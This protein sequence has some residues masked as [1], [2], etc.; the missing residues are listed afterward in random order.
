MLDPEEDT[1]AFTKAGHIK[2]GSVLQ[3]EPG[4]FDGDADLLSPTSDNSDAHEQ[5]FNGSFYSSTSTGSPVRSNDT[6]QTAQVL[7]QEA[8]SPPS[9]HS[10]S[11]PY[12][13]LHQSSSRVLDDM[14]DANVSDI[15][16]QEEQM[17]DTWNVGDTTASWD[18]DAPEPDLSIDDDDTIKL[19]AAQWNDQS[20]AFKLDPQLQEEPIEESN[21]SISLP[22]REPAFEQSNE[23]PALKEPPQE[24]LSNPAPS[25]DSP[26][27]P[28]PVEPARSPAPHSPDMSENVPSFVASTSKHD[29]QDELPRED[30][31]MDQ[32]P[33]Q[34]ATLSVASLR[35]RIRELTR[36]LNIVRSHSPAVSTAPSATDEPLVAPLEHYINSP[37]RREGHA[38]VGD[39]DVTTHT[40][41]EVRFASRSRENSPARESFREQGLSSPVKLGSAFRPP[42]TP[43]RGLGNHSESRLS[44]ESLSPSPPSSPP[45][46]SIPRIEFS[47]AAQPVVSTSKAQDAVQYADV[48]HTHTQ[49]PPS[50]E[51]GGET[52]RVASL[53]N[54]LRGLSSSPA[55]HLMSSPPNGAPEAAAS[56]SAVQSPRDEFPDSP[57]RNFTHQSPRSA[58]LSP[59]RPGLFSEAK[60][61]SPYRPNR[62]SPLKLG[63]PLKY[64]ADD[65]LQGPDP[66]SPA[67]RASQ[68]LSARSQASVDAH[69]STP[70]STGLMSFASI[71]AAADGDESEEDFVSP[72]SNASPVKRGDIPKSTKKLMEEL[73]SSPSAGLMSSPYL[74]LQQASSRVF[75]NTSI[76]VEG[77]LQQT[78]QD[79]LSVRSGRQLLESWAAENNEA[80]LENV[81]GVPSPNSHDRSRAEDALKAIPQGRVQIRTEGY[82]NQADDLT[83]ERDE[84]G[85]TISGL[86]D[87]TLMPFPA[88]NTAVAASA[89]LSRRPKTSLHRR[90]L[91][92]STIEIRS[93]DPEIAAR[94]AAILTTQHDYHVNNEDSEWEQ[95][96]KQRRRAQRL[97]ELLSRAQVEI[98]SQVDEQSHR[99]PSPQ[100][101]PVA[102][103][104]TARLEVPTKR[105]IHRHDAWTKSDWRHLE[106]CL[107]QLQKSYYDAG[108][109]EPRPDPEEVLQQFL[110]QLALTERALHGHWSK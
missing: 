43:Y 104:G 38:D 59:A 102:R 66:D 39:L 47:P 52:S 80:A 89:H 67:S 33:S 50:I 95:Q 55:A 79:R 30:P 18:M 78:D 64:Q 28:V 2:L 10:R 105:H 3:H 72:G 53:H 81:Q 86:G 45:L 110:Q 35:Q 63:S 99:D 32:A 4:L 74:D 62:S 37:G 109:L 40:V 108:V 94:V 16:Q 23:E 41:Q 106:A 58:E 107:K 56:I 84:L 100:H 21:S 44:N 83:E 25:L 57:R 20:Q 92:G 11:S 46:E 8:T 65:P 9:A 42:G 91:S 7:I 82:E 12:P 29:E 101:S 87:T 49:S 77:K 54:M 48:S 13:D 26:A 93:A 36:P 71:S 75:G 68:R 17:N 6:P 27:P 5:F 70:R 34:S 51:H 14:L 103:V 69:R 22:A 15:Q 76:G 31:I 97:E 60:F 73:T 19:P 96:E 88:G 90:T 1:F 24:I 61:E 85:E 98:T